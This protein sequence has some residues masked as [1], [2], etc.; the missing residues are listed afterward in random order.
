MKE[1]TI[2]T[3]SATNLAQAFTPLLKDS[4]WPT[5][6]LGISAFGAL[7]AAFF[8]FLSVKKQEEIKKAALID[9]IQRQFLEINS[10]LPMKQG[11]KLTDNHKQLLGNYFDYVSWQVR[12]KNFTLRDTELLRS[13]MKNQFEYFGKEYRKKHGKEYFDNWYWLINQINKE[14]RK[15]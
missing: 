12:N 11:A 15:K 8:S 14:G 9:S 13:E 4:I 7:L 10:K 1:L 3:E 5:I 2:A 6:L